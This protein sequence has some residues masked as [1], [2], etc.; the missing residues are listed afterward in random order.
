MELCL[1]FGRAQCRVMQD[2]RK[3]AATKYAGLRRYCL[4]M[5]LEA[6]L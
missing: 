1:A 5:T 6:V 2:A 3:G 4:E